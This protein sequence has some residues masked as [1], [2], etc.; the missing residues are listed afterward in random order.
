MILA[1]FAVLALLLATL[2]AA[3]ARGDYSS[4]DMKKYADSEYKGK[5][6]KVIKGVSLVMAKPDQAQMYKADQAQRQMEDRG[7]LKSGK[8]AE[9][10]HQFSI[11]G[12]AIEGDEGRA[13]VFTFDKPLKGVYDLSDDMAYISTANS[14]SSQVRV[15]NVEDL[16][17]DTA[18]ASAIVKMEDV[19][20]LYKGDDYSLMEFDEVYVT[21]PDGKTKELL[22]EQP[23]K[24]I[25]S[26]DRKM[27][28]IDGYPSFTR[29]MMESLKGAEQQT[30]S[31]DRMSMQEI[32][33]GEKSA[34]EMT[35]K[36]EKPEIV[37]EPAREITQ[38]T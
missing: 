36:Y 12:M 16:G 1:T 8:M 22:L 21:T 14:M 18:G 7:Q 3:V 11:T 34:Q 26:K 9:S 19:K 4:G 6:G 29:S 5:M 17:L 20:L 31:S 38:Q 10:I 15:G 2:P 23:V 25:Y 33:M 35:V 24:V 32:R 27:V 13:A 28:V 30:F 37:K